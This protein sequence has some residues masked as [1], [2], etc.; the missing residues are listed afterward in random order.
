MKIGDAL[1][2]WGIPG[3]AKHRPV[4][5]VDNSIQRQATNSYR[6]EACVF[7]EAECWCIHGM[8]SPPLNH[9]ENYFSVCT[10]IFLIPM[11]EDV[12]LIAWA[13]AWEFYAAG[14]SL[15]SFGADSVRCLTA[16]SVSLPLSARLCVFIHSCVWPYEP[17][18]MFSY[19]SSATCWK[20]I[21]DHQYEQ[22]VS[23]WG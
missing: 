16:S 11:S 21:N 5:A 4:K 6:L 8:F 13:A 17:R 2:L 7:S 18:W 10:C 15:H 12:H 14:S 9:E 22:R 20:V 1:W 19:S 23:L 3:R